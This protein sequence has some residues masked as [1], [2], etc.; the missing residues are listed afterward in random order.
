MKFSQNSREKTFLEDVR[1]HHTKVALLWLSGKYAS[2]KNVSPVVSFL[3]HGLF[4]LKPQSCH[5]WLLGN[6][7]IL[8]IRDNPRTV[9]NLKANISQ[10]VRNIFQKTQR[11][12][13]GRDILQFEMITV[14]D[15]CHL[16]RILL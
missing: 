4:I 2:Q 15:D 1:V 7:K 5:V 8:P 14:N 11:L 9:S 10:Y 12:T 3:I 13:V 6:F 16:K